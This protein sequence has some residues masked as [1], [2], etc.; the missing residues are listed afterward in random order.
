MAKAQYFVFC[1]ANTTEAFYDSDE[2]GLPTPYDT[3][4]EAVAAAKGFDSTS[5][6]VRSVASVIKRTSYKVEKIN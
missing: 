3:E 2:D 1:N 4:A 6:I 5:L